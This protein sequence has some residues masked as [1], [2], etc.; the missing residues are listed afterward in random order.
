MNRQCQGQGIVFGT[1]M[2]VVMFGRIDMGLFA[3][4]V[5]LQ[6]FPL[7]MLG[8]LPARVGDGVDQAQPLG[9][10][11]AEGQE[12]GQYFQFRQGG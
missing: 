11:K 3:R 2:M 8:V 9:K 1:D 6:R 7:R 5:G 10:Q 4:M 12:N